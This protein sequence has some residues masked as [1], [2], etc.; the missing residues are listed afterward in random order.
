MKRFM[1][2]RRHLPLAL[3]AWLVHGL[4]F[5]LMERR[6]EQWKMLREGNGHVGAHRYLLPSAD[7]ESRRPDLPDAYGVLAPY[8]LG[9]E[10]FFLI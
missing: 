9:Y 3:A 7:V 5:L 6:R 8:L 1:N 10:T 2:R 4:S